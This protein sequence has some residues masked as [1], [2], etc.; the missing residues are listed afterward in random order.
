MK[1]ENYKPS[2]SL[3]RLWQYEIDLL[4]A[5][6]AVCEKNKL[7]YYVIGGTLLGAARHKGFIPWDNDIDLIMP[8]DDYDQLWEIAKTE[9]KYPYFFQTTLSEKK[10]PFFRGH[11]QLRNSKV[12]G[13]CLCDE[14]KNINKG[15]FIDIFPL[16]RIPDDELEKQLWV[17]Q[18]TNQK[19]LMER[20]CKKIKMAKECLRI[21]AIFP[22]IFFSLFSFEKYFQSFNKEVLG[23]YRHKETE[24]VGNVSLGWMPQYVWPKE[25]FDGFCSLQ[26]EGITVKAPFD[27]QKILEISYGNWEKYPD[28]VDEGIGSLH[29]AIIFD[30]RQMFD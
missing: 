20:Y 1:P 12:L 18:I 29:G 24:Y 30:A 9:F 10:E 2:E 7:T 25:C 23:K 27:F 3:K 11:A 22:R 4:K 28:D 8:R 14:D 13:Y 21:S 19:K 15:V 16:D 6:I 5:F 26:F 17:Q